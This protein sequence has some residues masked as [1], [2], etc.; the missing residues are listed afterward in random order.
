MTSSVNAYQGTIQI[1][2]KPEDR[3]A[4]HYRWW[5]AEHHHV[6]H[7]GQRMNFDNHHYQVAILQDKSQEII[8]RKSTQCGISECEII[9]ALA[10]VDN[11]RNV[12]WVF[13]DQPL[14]NAFAK[15]RMDPTLNASPYYRSMVDRAKSRVRSGRQAS[16]EVAMKQIGSGTIA[17]VGSNTRAGFRSFSADDAIIDEVDECDQQNLPLV[18]GRLA[19][20]TFRT[21]WHVGNPSLQGFGID[22]L[23]RDSDQKRWRVRCDHCGTSQSIDWF[24]NVVQEVDE[25]IYELRDDAMGVVCVSCSKPIDR[26]AAG[27]WVAS[28]PDRDA[29]GYHI[30]Q[31]F[32]GSVPISAMWKAFN[33]GLTNESAMQAFYND[34]LGLPY[35]AKGSRLTEALLQRCVGDYPQVTTCES[36]TMGIDV[37]KELHVEVKAKDGRVIRLATV[38]DFETLDE[39]MSAYGITTCVIDALPETRKAREFA[40]RWPGQVW[41]CF[42]ESSDKASQFNVDPENQQVRVHRTQSMDQS[43]AAILKREIQFP[44]DAMSVDGWSAQMMAP[45]RLFESKGDTDSGR[46][47]W[48]EGD[49]PDHYRHA[50]NYR[51]VADRIEN[52]VGQAE[53]W[54]I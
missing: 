16:D 25:G 11:G 49:Q 28:Y 17:L 48:R 6:A 21:K 27:E 22:A 44:R 26:L 3:H 40:T 52:E 13:P 45:T 7:R 12:F 32:S 2:R 4:L 51:G 31:L 18:D 36:A 5:L 38:R 42:Y 43:H 19:H 47:V 8:V 50:N 15:E 23:Y 39:F 37:G 34:A 53:V 46:Y 35:T 30:S 41:L 20:S 54:F 10:L 9:H 33:V 24:T 14:R 1:A 29:S